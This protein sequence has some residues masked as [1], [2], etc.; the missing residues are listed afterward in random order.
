M[1]VSFKFKARDQETGVQTKTSFNGDLLPD[2]V[3]QF[4]DFLRGAGYVFDSL[5]VSPNNWRVNPDESPLGSMTNRGLH[6]VDTLVSFCGEIKSVFVTSSNRVLTK[7]D[8][9]TSCILWFK[10]GTRTNC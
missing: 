7:L 1:S 2:I 5:E 6:C 8:D 9:T 10:N 3:D 4:A